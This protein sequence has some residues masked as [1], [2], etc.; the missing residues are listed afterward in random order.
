MDD[1][2]RAVVVKVLHA[3]RRVQRHRP[4]HLPLP[5]RRVLGHVTGEDAVQ[6]ATGKEVVDEEALGAGAGGD[7]GGD[8]GDK[9]AVTDVPEGL[10]LCLE[11]A[12]TLSAAEG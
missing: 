5:E 9:V 12:L 11:L 2:R 3:P 8:K 6:R 4:P 1:A 10:H 7:V